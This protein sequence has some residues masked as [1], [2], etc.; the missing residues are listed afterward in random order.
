MGGDDVVYVLKGERLL[1]G[2]AE[3]RAGERGG[4]QLCGGGGE[5][6]DQGCR[7]ADGLATEGLQKLEP[8]HTGHVYIQQDNVWCLPPRPEQVQGLYAAAGL[9]H[10]QIKSRYAAT[11]DDRAKPAHGGVIVYK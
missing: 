7:T 2:A 9:R 1:I 6:I 5:D 3:E 11:Q 8:I 4:R 10:Y